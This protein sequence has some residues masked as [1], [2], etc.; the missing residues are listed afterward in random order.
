MKVADPSSCCDDDRV[1]ARQMAAL[2]HPV[3]LQ[4]L[5][6]LAARDACC[7]KDLV[8][9]LDL[10]QSTVSQHVRVLLDAGL[11][12]YK[13]ERQSSRYS[14]DGAGLQAATAALGSLVSSLNT[15]RSDAASS[16]PACPDSVIAAA[17]EEPAEPVHRTN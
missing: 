14:L 13:A 12:R 3:R 2:S 10:A 16:P 15:A 11:V 7:V 9:R 6:C 4:L 17:G 1:L 5:R 8:C